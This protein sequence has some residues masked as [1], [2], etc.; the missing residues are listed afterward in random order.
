[1]SLTTFVKIFDLMSWYKIFQILAIPDAITLLITGDEHCK[2][3]VLL[4]LFPSTKRGL[5]RTHSLLKGEHPPHSLQPGDQGRIPADKHPARLTVLITLI[6]QY[7]TQVTASPLLILHMALFFIDWEEAG[8][9]P[10]AAPTGELMTAPHTPPIF[11]HQIGA[12]HLFN[13]YHFTCQRDTT[14]TQLATQGGA[15]AAAR[16]ERTKRAVVTAAAAAADEQRS[17]YTVTDILEAIIAL[18]RYYEHINTSSE[19][20]PLIHQANFCT[21]THSI[22][23]DS[24]K[25]RAPLTFLTRATI[26]ADTVADYLCVPPVDTLAEVA[27]NI[28]C[29]LLSIETC[30]ILLTMPK[31]GSLLKT[32]IMPDLEHYFRHGNFENTLKL[33]CALFTDKPNRNSNFLMGLWDDNFTHNQGQ[34][35]QPFIQTTHDIARYALTH[36]RASMPEDVTDIFL[37]Y[38]ADLSPSAASRLRLQAPRPP[39]AATAAGTRRPAIPLGWQPGS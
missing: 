20:Y 19:P 4:S 32:Y 8:F 12:I 37:K 35:A 38:Y 26:V 31:Q 18:Q 33:F 13:R 1:V 36:K 10:H 3:A 7:S 14:A 23:S 39:M 11:R 27:P 30:C 5:K 24:D 9:N 29:P 25:T 2:Q 6:K 28:N 17:P 34:N 21:D 15:A 22:T 16:A